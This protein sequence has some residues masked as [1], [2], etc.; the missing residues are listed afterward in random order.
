MNKRHASRPAI[1]ESLE[2]RVVL[3]NG[4]EHVSVAADVFLPQMREVLTA[5]E[6]NR[7]ELSRDQIGSIIAGQLRGAYS[8]LRGGL[9]R[10]LDDMAASGD[11]DTFDA[12]VDALCV[13]MATRCAELLSTSPRAARSLT[14]SWQDAI[15]GPGPDS[16]NS[17]L[18]SLSA[19]PGDRSDVVGVVDD[20]L[21]GTLAAL[22]TFA[23]D[24]NARFPGADGGGAPV[25]PPAGWGGGPVDPPTTTP[26]PTTSR[27]PA[28]PTD[29]TTLAASP[30]R[31]DLSWTGSA[32][33]DGYKLERST[34]GTDY[35]QVATT[36]AGTT[37]FNDSA[38]LTA[39]TTYSYRVRA[40]SSRGDSA[41][42]NVVTAATPPLAP[43]DVPQ[44][45][46]LSTLTSGHES[47]KLHVHPSL[48]LFV[49]GREQVIPANTNITPRGLYP[50]HVHEGEPGV[51]HV[52]SNEIYTYRLRDFF[53]LWRFTTNDPTRVFNGQQFLG[54]PI[55]ATHR[56]TVTVDGQPSAA[57]ENTVLNNADGSLAS[58]G[59]KAIVIRS[60]T[61]PAPGS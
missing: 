51:L 12:D 54:R 2:E 44:S 29:L 36:A 24:P 10:T 26:P 23:R 42:S 31:I 17:R 6:V 53:D 18:T 20:S 13:G 1:L 39:G 8:A 46:L 14:P 16:L 5:A 28:A 7:W 38:G 19:D 33:V 55:D 60:E 27:P 4:V 45:V 25:D 48:R 30:G 21:R 35:A 49:D 15:N 58:Q 59:G 11:G 22:L 57:L 9:D 37:S 43:P 41:P 50:L 3:H 34:N 47:L 61:I 40:T 52:E 32:G 56:V